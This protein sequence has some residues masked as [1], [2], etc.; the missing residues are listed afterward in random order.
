MDCC[1]Q[2]TENAEWRH[3]DVGK[4]ITIITAMKPCPCG[5]FSDPQEACACAP[6]VVTKYQKRISG[7]LL[8]RIDVHYIEVPCVEYEKLSGN[9]VGETSEVIR[10]RVLVARDIQQARS[11]ILMRSAMSQLNLSHAPVIAREVWNLRARLQI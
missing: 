8:D 5:G 7:S 3:H 9:K 6:A 10:Q 11:R 1:F 2:N 4:K